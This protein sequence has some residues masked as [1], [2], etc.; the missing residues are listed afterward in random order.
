EDAPS[1]HRVPVLHLPQKGHRPTHLRRGSDQSIGAVQKIGH[2]EMI[3]QAPSSSFMA[4]LPVASSNPNQNP[5]SRPRQKS[6]K[7]YP[8]LGDGSE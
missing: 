7:P 6:D 5:T 4:D 1:E 8:A 2:E 3:K